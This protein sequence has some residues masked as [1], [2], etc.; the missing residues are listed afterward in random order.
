MF[1][2]VVDGIVVLECPNFSD[3][4]AAAIAAVGAR[5][6]VKDETHRLVYA[7]VYGQRWVRAEL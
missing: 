7:I 6:L 4:I 1:R 5:I 3:A 2:I